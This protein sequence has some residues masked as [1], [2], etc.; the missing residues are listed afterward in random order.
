MTSTLSVEQLRTK[1]EERREWHLAAL[2]EIESG[3]DQF[4]RLIA[5]AMGGREGATKP[6]SVAVA[7][8][9]KRAPDSLPEEAGDDT[10]PEKIL[11]W[12]NEQSGSFDVKA[13]PEINA[14]YG[15][16]LDEKRVSDVFRNLLKRHKVH[17]VQRGGPRKPALYANF[18]YRAPVLVD[19]GQGD[20][21][22]EPEPG[23]FPGT[24]E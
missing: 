5:L 7:P 21:E 16:N 6:P 17:L 23:L 12:I 14:R 22:P 20:T 9:E 18:T 1:L 24:E 11:E 13:T 8:K 15:L 10:V 19:I 2:R 4:D 3:L